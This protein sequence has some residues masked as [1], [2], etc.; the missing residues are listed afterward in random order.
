[1]HRPGH[2]SHGD[3]RSEARSTPS[4]GPQAVYR[5]QLAPFFRET[6]FGYC[7]F[8]RYD[9]HSELQHG[10]AFKRGCNDSDDDDDDMMMMTH[11]NSQILY[12]IKLPTAE[13]TNF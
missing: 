12:E 3:L 13:D 2:C 7:C 6:A 4:C 8:N 5:D 9:P 10:S 1:M 11:E